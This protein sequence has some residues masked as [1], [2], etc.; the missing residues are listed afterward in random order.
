MTDVLSKLERDDVGRVLVV[1]PDGDVVGIITTTDLAR[2]LRRA[3]ELAG[4]RA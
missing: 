3:N 4:R 2:W 1:T